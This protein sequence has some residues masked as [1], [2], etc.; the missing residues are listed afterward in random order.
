MSPEPDPRAVAELR[1]ER[2]LKQIRAADLAIE[3]AVARRDALIREAVAHRVP[4][5]DIMAAAR[6]SRTRIY[7]ITSPDPEN[8]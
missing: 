2:L 7:Q 8:K 4:R 6:L 5:A 1:A 3:K